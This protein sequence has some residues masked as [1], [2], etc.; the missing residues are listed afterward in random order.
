MLRRAWDGGEGG[1]EVT[2]RFISRVVR[3]LTGSGR[4]FLVQSSQNRPE[5]TISKLHRQGL[6][7]R[8]IAEESF[9]FERLYLLEA[10][11]KEEENG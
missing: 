10:S 5:E 8:I 2:D 11:R 9:F 7:T 3:H 4:V 6:E 1:R